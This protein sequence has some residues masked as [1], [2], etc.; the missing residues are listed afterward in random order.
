MFNIYQLLI[1]QYS[2]SHRVYPRRYLHASLETLV[3][4]LIVTW[5]VTLSWY[6][7]E[8]W[9]HPKYITLG[10]FNFCFGWYAATS[11]PPRTHRPLASHRA[12]APLRDF[13]PGNYIGLFMCSLQVYFLWR[14][15]ILVTMRLKMHGAPNW[16]DKGAALWTYFHAVSAS[17]FLLIW[18]LG[19]ISAYD[20]P[21]HI[22]KLGLLPGPE[23]EQ[24]SGTVTW[25]AHTEAFICLIVA[26]YFSYVFAYLEGRFGTQNTVKP[27]HTYYIIAFSISVV[28]FLAVYLTQDSHETSGLYGKNHP[29][30]EECKE[31]P[32]S[33]PGSFFI[34]DQVHCSYL[35]GQW[36]IVANWFWFFCWL[37][38]PYFTPN[39]PAITE[40]YQF[41]EELEDDDEAALAGIQMH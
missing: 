32:R 22:P 15:A 13:P 5:T 17:C 29:D 33:V 1:D 26:S 19:P 30:A 39:E 25:S 11:S 20:G 31:Q 23:E 9:K 14:Y 4:A 6:P 38:A 37:A 7:D 2:G 18:L 10:A 36:T 12:C 28:F 3:M 24:E 40:S 21:I 27:M 35:S 16:V 8:A 34:A 41:A